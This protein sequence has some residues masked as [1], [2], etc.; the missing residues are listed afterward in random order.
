MP[1]HLAPQAA[2]IELPWTPPQEF[3]GY[4][5][6]GLLGRGGMGAVYLG[7]DQ[8]LD[9]PVAIKFI[10]SAHEKAREICLNEAR[11]AAKLQHPN[12]V[13][14]YRVGEID[15]HPYIVSEYI[16][17]QGLNQLTLPLSWQRAL[18]L[19]IGLAAGLAAAHQR[20]I[21]H[22]DLKPSNAILGADG[23]I[24]LLDFGLAKIIESSVTQEELPSLPNIVAMAASDLD[25]SQDTIDLGGSP[26][27]PPAQAL[28]PAPVLAA[29]AAPEPPP[30]DKTAGPLSAADTDASV[31]A[32][33]PVFMAPEVLRG[34][35][36]SRR[37]DIYSMGALLYT[38]CT[39]DPPFRGLPLL[40]LVRVVNEVDAL[41]LSDAVPGVNPGFAAVVDRC[42]RRNP[43]DRFATAD[44][45]REALE[46]VLH[47]QESADVPEGNPYRGLLPYE[48]RDRALFF[49]RRSEVGTLV[50][51]LRNERSLLVI[52]DSGVGKSSLVRAG[53]LPLI[54][55]GVL[56]HKRTWQYA[57][58]T[59]GHNPHAA[60]LRALR[61]LLGLPRAQQGKRLAR[62]PAA[63]GRELHAL[64]GE[65]KGAVL[66]VDQLEELVTQSDPAEAAWAAEAMESLIGGS[67][68]FRLILVA[69]ADHLSRLGALPRL[70]EE[71]S[72]AFYLLRPLSREK[73]AEVIVGPA[74]RKGV[75]FGSEELVRSLAES[76]AG[77]DSGLPLLSFALAELW[78]ARSGGVITE[79]ALKSIGGVEGALARHA[80]HVIARLNPAE[81]KEARQLLLSLLTPTGAQRRLGRDEL[82]Q[83]SA[84][85]RAVL[86]K[87]VQGRLVVAR[88]SPE[89]ASYELAHETLIKGSATLRGWL[90][91]Q[92]ERRTIG[93]RLT[94]AAQEWR[95]LGRRR[96]GL[97]SSRQIEE[98]ALLDTR[99]MASQEM[100]FLQASR[101]LLWRQRQIRLG[102]LVGV[103]LLAALLGLGVRLNTQ[104]TAYQQVSELLTHGR[105]YLAELRELDR[106]IEELTL[107]A[108][109]AFDQQRLEPGERLWSEVL[110]K[111]KLR[112]QAQNNTLAFMKSANKTTSRMRGDALL[113]G[114]EVY[115]VL[116]DIAERE[117]DREQLTAALGK[118]PK[119]DVSGEMTRRWNVPGR[120]SLQSSQHAE[121]H[122]QRYVLDDELRLRLDAEQRLGQAPLSDLALAPGSYL[123]TLRAPQR[124]EVRYPLRIGRAEQVQVDVELPQKDAIPADF[125]YVPAGPVLFGTQH[126]EEI[127]SSVMQT[128]PIHAVNVPGFLISR[129]E[130]TY[131]Q[132]LEY[133]RA[134]AREQPGPAAVATPMTL[135]RRSDGKFM[136]SLRIGQQILRAAEGEPLLYGGRKERKQ[137]DWLKLPV[138]GILPEEALAF[139]AWLSIKWQGEKHPHWARLCSE[140]EWERAARGADDREFPHGNALAPGDANYAETHQSTGTDLEIGASELPTVGPD[141]V[142]SY[143]ASVSPFGVEDMAG[144]IAEWVI[145]TLRPGQF[146]LR[147]GHFYSQHNGLRVAAR[148][149]ADPSLRDLGAGL[150]ICASM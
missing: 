114:A 24:K 12:V 83:G 72:R 76:A 96:E 122:I 86:E 53:L 42:L 102:L 3:D 55:E 87:L 46:A 60:L 74:R 146:L 22:R 67:S 95:R 118:F 109:H 58:M 23:T 7:H 135:S 43:E 17:G 148:Q 147:G 119:Y 69:R 6:R 144:N 66:V 4:K 142:G 127:R 133:L 13:A 125:V 129:R 93:Q 104:R 10:L 38:L 8:L 15:G 128:V 63:L 120:L 1:D 75:S 49:G 132:W 89:G 71:I 90:E 14:I 57:V 64:L 88:E 105:A 36:S 73:L 150:R 37:S 56:D 91:Q 44:E 100:E 124:A 16:R 45:L 94:Q 61:E 54:A 77:T 97:W 143:A 149:P 30:A 139:A 62:E 40:D 35:P 70:G 25:L 130:V 47:S 81:Q 65:S 145:S 107:Q 26:R 41:P 115:F 33:T 18:E 112:Q 48:P 113:F 138:S 137:V 98:A 50:E 79:Q 2:P 116:A 131:Q 126:D 121:V 52:G 51:R 29:P 103:P 59:P 5:V 136:L 39:K 85:A 32:G 34:E 101:R 92:G 82:V 80:D 84:E 134:T 21:L 106:Q 27:P 19:G 31:L 68:G 20:G 110:R 111:R 9:R 99:E 117:H 11:A 140:L 108:A 78:E 123:L 28:R 141:E